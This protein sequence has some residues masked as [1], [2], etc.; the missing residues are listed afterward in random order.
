ML[1]NYTEL[2]KLGEQKWPGRN[3]QDRASNSFCKFGKHIKQKSLKPAGI[4]QVNNN[5]SK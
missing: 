5:N 3:P 1:T 2:T 4:S